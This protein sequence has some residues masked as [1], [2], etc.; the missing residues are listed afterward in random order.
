MRV[1]WVL[2]KAWNIVYDDT[3]REIMREVATEMKIPVGDVERMNTAWWKYIGEM[4]MRPELPHIRMTYLLAMKPSSKKLYGYCEKVGVLID[5]IVNGATVN[6]NKKVGDV[7]VMNKHLWTLQNTYFRLE[8]ER[9]RR[10]KKVRE[11]TEMEAEALR[12]YEGSKKR[13]I[14]VRMVEAR[15]L[16]SQK[17]NGDDRTE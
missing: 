8:A 3:W 14:S 7:E 17:L 16:K 11:M 4:M 9:A 2:S 13:L 1:K 10:K 15:Q 12:R 6:G 5:K